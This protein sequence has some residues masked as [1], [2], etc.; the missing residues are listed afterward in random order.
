M[1]SVCEMVVG[2]AARWPSVTL[3]IYAF[4]SHSTYCVFNILIIICF[5]TLS[6]VQLKVGSTIL[7]FNGASALE[8][9]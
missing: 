9:L 5:N 7:C 3:Y 8:T 4:A 2:I 1:T 6:L